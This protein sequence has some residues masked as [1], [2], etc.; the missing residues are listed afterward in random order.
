MPGCPSFGTPGMAAV[1]LTRAGFSC[2]DQSHYEVHRW[3]DL[4]GLPELWQPRYGRCWNDPCGEPRA[5]TN[6][7]MGATA[8]LT[9][10][11][12]SCFVNPGMDRR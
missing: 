7:T 1:G 4:C 2:F 9:R 11:G 8:G 3:I 5:S 12:F 6:P 10:A